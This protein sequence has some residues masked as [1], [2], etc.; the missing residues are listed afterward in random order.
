[1]E[2]I[3]VQELKRK[4]EN[5]EEFHLIDVRET[6]EYEEANLGGELI[7]LGELS[8]HLDKM[9]DWKDDEIILMCRSG[10]RSGKAQQF[11]EMNDFSNVYN[12]EGGILA[13]QEM[14]SNQ[15]S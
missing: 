3:S 15:N 10:A 13:W 12:L 8:D 6:Y 4:L 9:E 2:E 11:L 5:K 14:E 1:M 7:P